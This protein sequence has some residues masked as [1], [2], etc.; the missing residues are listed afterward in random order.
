MGVMSAGRDIFLDD[1]CWSSGERPSWQALVRQ[2]KRSAVA[3]AIG[4]PHDATRCGY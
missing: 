1:D 3:I 4:H 2:A